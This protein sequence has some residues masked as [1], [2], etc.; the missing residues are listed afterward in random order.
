[1]W[2]LHLWQELTT[3]QV[4]YMQQ[5]YVCLNLSVFIMTYIFYIRGWWHGSKSFK[6]N[7]WCMADFC[8]LKCLHSMRSNKTSECYSPPNAM[9]T[10]S[11]K[12]SGISRGLLDPL[13][14]VAVCKQIEAIS[15][16]LV[17]SQLDRIPCLKA[18]IIGHGPCGLS[19]IVMM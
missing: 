13:S 16:R 19:W 5:K 14:S 2:S 8:V 15:L 12:S 11:T 7:Q 9:R 6:H 1:M 4:K 17:Y 18:L 3:L 10:L